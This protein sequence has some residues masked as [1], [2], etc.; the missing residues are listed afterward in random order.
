M[1]MPPTVV[2]SRGQMSCDMGSQHHRWTESAVPIHV[3]QAEL[4]KPVALP[5]GKADRKGRR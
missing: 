2:G 1:L 5:R 3:T 4:G